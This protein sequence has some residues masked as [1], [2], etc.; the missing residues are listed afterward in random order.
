MNIELTS[1]VADGSESIFASLKIWSD[2]KKKKINSVYSHS[3]SYK[4]SKN[5]KVNIKIVD[6]FTSPLGLTNIGDTN[7]E[8]S[9]SWGS[10]M[11]SKASSMSGLSDL[12]NIKNTIIEE[13]SYANSDTSVV[14]DMENNTTSRKTHTCTYVLDSKKLHSVRLHISEKHNFDLVKLFALNIGIS[15]LPDKT[16]VSYRTQFSFVLIGMCNKWDALICKGLKFK[17]SLPLNFLSDTIYYPS[18]YGL[19]FFVQ[20]L[21]WYSVHLLNSSVHIHVSASD[22]FL[23][24]MVHILF[25]CDLFLGGSLANLFQFHGGVPMSVVLDKLQFLRSLSPTCLLVLDSVGSLNILESQDFVSVHNYFLQI[26]ADSLLVYTD[27]PLS[28]LGSIGY[29]T[30]AAA[31]FKN[32]DLGLGVGVSGLML[33]ILV[34]LQTIA[35]ALECVPFLC[36]VNLFSDSQSALNA[37][38]AVVDCNMCDIGKFFNTDHWAV[39]V[40][41]DLGGLLDVQ[42]NSLHKQ[43]NRDWWKFDFKSA[44]VNK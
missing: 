9:K 38:N 43:V 4:K 29:K 36:S 12:E 27:R 30:G 39:S 18:F 19:K 28:N 20:V 24:G 10:E 14:N 32:I 42:L 13:I 41:V 26:G 11:E 5:S 31:F 44:D 16:I 33:S 8:F 3:A 34:E 22:N 23:A 6:L 37:F 35:L 40:S 2:A 25:D 7:G 15:V 17:S 21:C 1:S